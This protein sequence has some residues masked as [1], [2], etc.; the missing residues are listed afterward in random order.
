METCSQHHCYRITSILCRERGFLIFYFHKFSL[1]PLLST[2]NYQVNDV[3]SSLNYQFRT[4]KMYK[5]FSVFKSYWNIFQIRLILTVNN[6]L[7]IFF[8]YLL[9]YNF[10][11]F[12]DVYHSPVSGKS[13]QIFFGLNNSLVLMLALILL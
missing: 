9:N 3:G 7:T 5:S 2:R 4:I 10:I 6:F 8:E 1:H 12:V 13:L 11:A